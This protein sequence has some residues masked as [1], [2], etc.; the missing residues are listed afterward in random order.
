ME[1][2]I[3]VWDAVSLFFNEN[4]F[5]KI[6]LSIISSFVFIF[7]LLKTMRP[8]IQIS[9]EIC[10]KDIGGQDWYIFK[11]VNRSRYD[12][13]DIKFRLIQKTP[14]LANKGSKINYQLNEL[15]LSTTHEDHFAKCRRKHGYGD[16]ALLLRTDHNIEN[17]IKDKDNSIKLTVTGRHGLTNLTRIKSQDFNKISQINDG[18]EFKFGRSLDVM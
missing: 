14:Y 2:L 1:V 17:D 11:V 9:P 16:H 4:I 3:A 5:G 10:R 15:P 8:N 6:I 12:L 13:Y 18:K 7:L